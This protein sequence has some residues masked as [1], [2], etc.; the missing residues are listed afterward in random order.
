[1]Q[2]TALAGRTQRARALPSRRRL[3]RWRGGAAA[4]AAAEMMAPSVATAVVVVSFVSER[5]E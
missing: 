2:V 5:G 1:M 3:V 4:G